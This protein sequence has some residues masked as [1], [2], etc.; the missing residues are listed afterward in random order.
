MALLGSSVDP[1]LFLQDYSG[2]TRAA[3]IQAQG[4]QNLGAAIGQGIK[5]YGKIVD[6]RKKTDA[7]IKADDVSIESAIKL[8]KSLGIDINSYLEPIQALRKDPNTTPAQSLALG[9]AA[10]QGISNAFTLGIGAQE[11]QSAQQRA[12]ME[13]QYKEAQ[14]GMQER[15]TRAAEFKAQQSAIPKLE[16]KKRTVNIDGEAIEVDIDEDQ[17]GNKYVP[18]TGEPIKNL[19][20][21]VTDEEGW[22]GEAM[23]TPTSQVMPSNGMFGFTYNTRD[24]L[25]ASTANARQISLD[26]N[27]AANKNAKGIEIIIPNN[28]TSIERALAMDYVNQTKEFFASKGVDVPVRGVKTAAENKRGS[29]NRFHTEPF[30]VHDSASRAAIESDPDG[31]AQVLANTIG[32]IPGAMFIP[33][34]KSNDPGASA[35]GI[36][37]R[38]FAKG[39][40]I[41]ALERLSKQQSASTR[42]SGIDNALAM[43]GDINQ[44][45]MGTQQQKAEVARMIE[46]GAGMATAQN[47]PQGAM[48]TEASLTNQQPQLPQTR[49]IVRGVPVKPQGA[50][51]REAKIITGDVAQSLNLD[52]RGTYEATYE[53]GRLIGVQTVKAAPTISETLA[54]E[55]REEEK[56]TK[57]QMA[58]ATTEKS[59]RMI[60]LMTGLKNSPGF[61]NLFGANWYPKGMR[62]T[63]GADAAALFKQIEAMG[64]MEAIKDMKGQGALSDAEGQKASAAFV[65]ITQDMSEDA[66]KKKID[67]VIGYIKKGQERLQSGKLI[68]TQTTQPT[69]PS[70]S[71]ANSYFNQYQNQPP[72]R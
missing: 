45:A 65:G 40:I 39:T 58:A 11:R 23:P 57:Q 28:A 56:V 12:M 72:A 70:I 50:A 32:K 16:G 33:P 35:N 19:E 54:L 41:P 5:G 59:E 25:P 20:K 7:Q 60:E 55:K 43:T 37:E 3:E 44:Q 14:L 71:G 47:I 31:Y 27:A 64:F 66:A 26:F 61:E 42:P 34:H 69:S 4:M 18:G 30:F 1:R 48:P 53:D 63:A 49:K 2:F 29:A 6:E 36:N 46:Q 15:T 21:Y 51:Q 22:R 17:Y 8:G 68:P 62:G 67:E 52:P 13:Q 24:K 9:R 10:A 38:D